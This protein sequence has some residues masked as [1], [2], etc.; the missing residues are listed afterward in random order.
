MP[1]AE[2]LGNIKEADL[3]SWPMAI[4]TLQARY[5]QAD[6]IIPGHGTP[7]GQELLAHTLSMLSD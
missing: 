2:T 5:S 3:V 1:K 4:R 6:L 7:G